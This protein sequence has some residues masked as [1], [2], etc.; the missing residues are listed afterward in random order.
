MIFFK[1]ENEVQRRF[2]KGHYRA[3][4]SPTDSKLRHPRTLQLDALLWEAAAKSIN[5]LAAL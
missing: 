4:V 3:F 1:N 2:F 5:Q